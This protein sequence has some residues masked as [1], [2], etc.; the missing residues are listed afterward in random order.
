[1]YLAK[2]PWPKSMAEQAQAVRAAL[3]ALDGP[4]TSKQVAKA[5]KGARAARVIELLET[6]ASLRQGRLV[7]GDRFVAQ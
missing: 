3:V 6:L 1:M 4:V 7:V 2:Q 5:F